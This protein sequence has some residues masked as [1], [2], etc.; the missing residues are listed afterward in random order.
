MAEGLQATHPSGR[1]PPHCPLDGIHPF[2]QSPS[3]RI[4]LV[5]PVAENLYRQQDSALKLD[6]TALTLSGTAGV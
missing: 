1:E 5:Q 3:G 4:G 6:N 2:G